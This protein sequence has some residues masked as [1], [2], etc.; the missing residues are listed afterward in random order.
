MLTRRKRS[1]LSPVPVVAVVAEG[2]ATE[3]V[4]AV[5]KKLGPG[6]ADGVFV[7]G[8]VCDVLDVTDCTGVVRF[9]TPPPRIA[10]RLF[11]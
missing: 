11:K 4:I 10:S 7:V 5:V 9:D 8:C 6:V 1:F 2:L 3:V